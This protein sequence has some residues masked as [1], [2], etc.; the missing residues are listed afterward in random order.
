MTV[1]DLN[2]R[3]S[4]KRPAEPAALYLS[5]TS[6]HPAKKGEI[7]L[8]CGGTQGVGPSLVLFLLHATKRARKMGVNKNQKRRGTDHESE[9]SS[10]NRTRSSYQRNV[11]VVAS[12]GRVLDDVPSWING[13]SELYG[14]T[15]SNR[16]GGTAC[17]T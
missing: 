2:R 7:K 13:N 3:R 5:L 17:F 9:I 1:I 4:S 12:G 15:R 16:D 14:G 6:P 11:P 10:T 8:G